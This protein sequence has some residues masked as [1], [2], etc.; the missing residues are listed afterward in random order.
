MPGGIHAPTAETLPKGAVEVVD[1]VGASAGAR[2]CSARPQVQPRDRRHRVRLRRHRHDLD[3]RCRST[4]ATTGTGASRRAATTATSAIRTSYVR[5]AKAPG[6]L[7]FGGQLG[8]WVPGQGCAVD[9]GS[10]DL[11]RRCAAWCRCRPVRACSRS[12]AGF[13]L[14]NSA[15]SVD[16]PMK[17]SLAG[18]RV[19]RRLRLQRGVRRR[20]AAHSRPGKAWVGLEG[21]LDAFIGVADADAARCRARSAGTLI[22][23]RRRHRRLS[24][25]PTAA[26][27]VAFVEGAKVPGHRGAQVHGRQHPADPV[28]AGDHRWPRARRRASAARRRGRRSSRRTAT[29][30][31]R[32]TARRSRC[33]CS[34]S[35]AAR[36]STTA[37]KPVVGAKVSFTLKNSQVRPTATDDKGA[38][39]VDGRADRQDAS[40]ATSSRS[41]RPASRS[42][43]RSTARSRAR[44]PCTS[45]GRPN[46][47]PPITLEP[48]LPPGQ[49]RGVVRTLP[50]WQ[51]DRGRDH[52]GRRRASKA[53]DRA[54][55][56]RSRSTSRRVSTRSRSKIGGSQAAGARRHDRSQRCRNQ[57]HRPPEVTGSSAS[58]WACCSVVAA[59]AGCKTKPRDRRARR[60]PTARSSARR[61]TGAWG[62]A[63]IGTKYYLGDAARTADGGA[64]LELAAAGAHRDAAA[65]GAALRRRQGWQRADRRRAR[66]DRSA[67][68]RQLQARRRQR[69]DRRQ[70]RDPHHREGAGRELDRADRRCGADHRRRRQGGRPRDRQVVRARHR[71]DRGRQGCRRRR[72]ACRRCRRSPD[73]P[74]ERRREAARS[75]SPAR[76]P[77]CCSPATTKWVPLPAGAGAL[78]K[79]AK[80]RL[81]AGTTAKL[82]ASGDDARAGRRLAHRDRRRSAR[83]ASSSAVAHATVPAAQQGKVGVPGGAVALEGTE[84]G[85]AEAQLDV[86]AKGEAK[87]TMLRGSAQA[88]RHAAAPTLDMKSRRERV[89]REGRRDPPA[90]GD[91]RL[92]RHAVTVGDRDA[93]RSTIRRARPRCGSTSTASAAAAA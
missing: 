75:R 84:Q 32:R 7:L 90:R 78:P 51:A 53:A 35:S 76:R 40:R 50:G 62:G 48:V 5:V 68:R 89:A 67:G 56:V 22:V 66:R 13:R 15:K 73:A 59:L 36:S 23:P 37:G 64:Q 83:S 24:H 85:P 60:R 41:T 49:L 17:L 70:R 45:R 61:P 55:T 93:S 1:A 12:T 33:R 82:V 18:S 87:V 43:S 19:A 71:A 4:A 6:T 10:R 77:R 34:P 11:G 27:R 79:G 2:A 52:H 9:R 26:R 31:T 3:R 30:T 58:R 46:T 54:R 29:S 16:D 57:E 72:R 8:V 42:P 14:D 80:M 20:A 88:R 74:A 25:Q 38:W 65:H 44:R 86:N 21:S 91:S 39:S 28:R 81:G 63:P 92:L 69:Q 47:V